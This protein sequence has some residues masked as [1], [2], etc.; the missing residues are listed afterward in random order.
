MKLS[1]WLYAISA[2]LFIT[3]FTVDMQEMRDKQ[4]AIWL[5]ADLNHIEREV[6]SADKS[7]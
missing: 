6:N 2:G 7:A 1:T 5:D 3:A 4:S